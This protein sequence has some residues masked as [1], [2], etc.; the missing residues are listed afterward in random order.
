VADRTPATALAVRERGYT[1]PY[2]SGFWVSPNLNEQTP[3]LLWPQCLDVY[4]AM[5]RQDAQVSSVFR[6]VTAPILRTQWRVD[7]TGCRPEVTAH[8]AADLGLPVVGEGNEVSA[9]RTRDRF[10]WPRHLRLALLMLRYGHSYFEQVYRIDEGDG[11]AHLRK[12]GWRPPKTIARFNVAKD[13]GLV[14]IEQFATFGQSGTV[15]LPVSRLVGYVHD[16]EGGNWTGQ[17][18]LRPAY[19]NWL[20]KD[21]LLRTDTQSKDRNGMGIPVYEGAPNETDLAAGQEIASNVRAGD[22]SGA[23]IPSGASLELKGVTGALPNALESVKYHDEQIARAVLAHFLNLGT[24]TGSWALGSTFADF[25]TLSLQSVAEEVRDVATM[26]VVEDL[27]DLNYGATEPAPRLVFDEIGSN[28][29][30]ILQAVAYLVGA[31]VL[32]PDE[33]LEQFIR[34]AMGLPPHQ[35]GGPFAPPSPA[36]QEAPE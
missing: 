31:G 24:Q 12:L 1:V 8:V 13:G 20:L 5:N 17:S 16:Q 21:R 28:H 14:S 25:F 23:A 29:D 15:T 6:A 11:L 33:D 26:H 35:G 18:L 34:T 2:P 9:I 3:E 4:D 22:N 19:K 10:S 27:V 30:A 32:R 36:P 7:G